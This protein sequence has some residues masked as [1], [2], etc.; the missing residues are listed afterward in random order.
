MR[1]R[2]LT[3]IELLVVLA[4]IGLLAAITIGAVQYARET[5][6]R[7]QCGSNLKQVGIALQSYH[8]AF[9]CFP[10]GNTRG[11]SFHTAILPQLEQ[12]NVAAMID[13][14]KQPSALANVAARRQPISVY[15]CPSDPGA[16][17]VG[18]DGS[19]GT[20]YAANFGTGVQAAGYNC[21]FRSA[22][23][24]QPNGV[25]IA[26]I[27][28]GLSR[29]AAVA[30]ILMGIGAPETGRSIVATAPLGGPLQLDAFAAACDAISLSSYPGA[31]DSWS[32]GRS[33]LDGD[34]SDTGYNHIL[35]P[36]H[37]CCTNGTSVPDGA[38]SAGSGHANGAQVL[39]ADG[40]MEYIAS[41]VDRGVWRAI[42]SR[43]GGEAN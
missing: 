20:N 31:A 42:G 39:F 36:N 19:F 6:R 25:R 41:G 34:L 10:L 24:A 3:L 1:R 17:V 40:H 21:I 28:D 38:Y 7:S 33:W 22:D 16:A 8:D 12:A 2:G 13:R 27:T 5:A 32:R 43:N 29:T 11:F 26:E 23:F 18:G 14:S 37:N 30:E 35:P 15:L 4:I 9:G